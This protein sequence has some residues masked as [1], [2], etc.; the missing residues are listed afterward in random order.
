MTIAEAN[1]VKDKLVAVP[2][3]PLP[4]N[5]HA[6]TGH[7]LPAQESKVYKQL[8]SLKE[9]AKVNEMKLNFKQN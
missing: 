9:Y 7:A 1:K 8:N 2:L 3:R 5:Y 6:R 4:D